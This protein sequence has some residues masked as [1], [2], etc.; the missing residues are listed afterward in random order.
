MKKKNKL[1][2]SLK[3]TLKHWKI[4]IYLFI[5]NIFLMYIYM[6][7]DSINYFFENPLESIVVGFIGSFNI[8][9]I[10]LTL[11]MPAIF[12]SYFI[13]SL[14]IK[15][16]LIIFLTLMLYVIFGWVFTFLI[17]IAFNLPNADLQEFGLFKGVEYILLIMHTFVTYG[18]YLYFYKKIREE[19]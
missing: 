7:I 14:K 1:I 12:L 13:S 10:M 17:F 15:K 18:N 3:K 9:L 5:I 19:K 16:Q 2:L 4:T 6:I 11:L 8:S